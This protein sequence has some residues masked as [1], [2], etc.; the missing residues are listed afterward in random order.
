MLNS[1]GGGMHR[2]LLTCPREPGTSLTFTC[3]KS[4]IMP[5]SSPNRG[6]RGFQMT[7]ALPSDSST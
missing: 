7:G 1:R 5:R 6:V 2:S 4:E 3:I